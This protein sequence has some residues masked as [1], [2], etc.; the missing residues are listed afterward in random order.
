MKVQALDPVLMLERCRRAGIG[1]DRQC[2]ILQT[3]PTWESWLSLGY[4]DHLG[5]T[6]HLISWRHMAR[7]K[8]G[9]TV[10]RL[11]ELVE[12]GFAVTPKRCK[13]KLV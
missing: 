3:P 12:D 1:S 9:L 13:Q 7:Y 6:I 10:P 2:C 11:Q 4:A 5:S 8:R